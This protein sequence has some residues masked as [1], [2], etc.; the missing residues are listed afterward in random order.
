MI[1]QQINLTF[2]FKQISIKMIDRNISHSIFN[3]LIF[4]QLSIKM[5]QRN[6]IT[7]SLTITQY[8]FTYECCNIP[9]F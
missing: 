9:K 6:N 4:K 1:F 8:S 3:N 5:I 2:I 7:L